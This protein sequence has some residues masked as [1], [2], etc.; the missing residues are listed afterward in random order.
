MCHA[1]V[2]KLSVQTYVSQFMALDHDEL[3]AMAKNEAVLLAAQVCM[4]IYVCWWCVC[5][6]HKECELCVYANNNTHTHTHIHTR[7]APAPEKVSWRPLR[8]NR[9]ASLSKRL[10]ATPLPVES[11]V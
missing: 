3:A 1:K 4:C 7:S 10:P 11:R 5:L 6:K 9:P 8:T 2:D